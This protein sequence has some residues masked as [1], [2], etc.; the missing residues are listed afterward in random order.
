M[1]SKRWAK[2]ILIAFNA[3]A[4]LAVDIVTR[5]LKKRI[6]EHTEVCESAVDHIEGKKVAITDEQESPS[7]APV[8]PEVPTGE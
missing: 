2:F 4:M 6:A 8:S 7:D 1:F 3:V 5:I